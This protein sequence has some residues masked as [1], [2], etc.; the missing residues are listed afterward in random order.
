MS[1]TSEPK[2]IDTIDKSHA[3]V[4]IPL[5][6]SLYSLN[7]V[8][9]AFFKEQTGI[10]DDEELKQHVLSVQK[11]A[12]AVYGYPCIRKF[13]FTSLKISRH[14]AYTIVQQLHVKRPDA[15]LLDMGCCFG[16]DIRKAVLDGWPVENVI[17]S[18]LRPEFWTCGHELFKSDASTFPAAFIGG[19][20]FDSAFLT[21]H[22]VFTSS[23]PPT[24]RRPGS[25]KDIKTLTQLHGHISAIHAASFFHLFD[26]SKQLEVAKRL[27]SLL[28]PQPGSTLFG[29][30]AAT[31]VAGFKT[32]PAVPSFG[33]FCHSPESWT[34]LWNGK[35][36]EKGTVD[37]QTSMVEVENPGAEAD[38][39]DYKFYTMSWSVTRL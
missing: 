14:P 26:E 38:A 37:V 39:L 16:N 18:D 11:S 21:P 22:P 4:N 17:A 31:L 29:S 23:S 15:I 27:G 36:F 35:I 1:T 19:D 33:M 9:T 3:L 12:Y 32:H 10:Q 7:D 2:S 30:H 28:S 5:D 24:N 25:L 20:A 13:A 6:E 34:E 8:E